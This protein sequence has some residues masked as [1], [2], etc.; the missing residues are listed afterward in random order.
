LATH[1]WLLQAGTGGWTQAMAGQTIGVSVQWACQ[2]ALFA[3]QAVLESG[4]PAQLAQ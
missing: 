4:A 2:A 1:W 3:E